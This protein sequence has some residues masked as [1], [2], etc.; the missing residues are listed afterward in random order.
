VI[1]QHHRVK[2]QAKNNTLCDA[3][4]KH[5]HIHGTYRTIECL[6]QS[7]MFVSLAGNVMRLNCLHTGKHKISY[8][9]REERSLGTAPRQATHYNLVRLR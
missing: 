7:R 9:R 5:T 4:R 3:E 1:S 8:A 6:S 2:G